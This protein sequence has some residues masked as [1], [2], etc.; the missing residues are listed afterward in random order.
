M[1]RGVCIAVAVLALT[2][3]PAFAQSTG[4]IVGTVTDAVTSAP[5]ASG[6]SSDLLVTLLHSS[7]QV[8]GNQATNALG[9]Y[10]F[11]GLTPG[12]YFVKVTTATTG[13]IP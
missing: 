11:T 8:F 7:G 3:T 6:G 10:A 2:S 13:Y 1:L 12:I 5:L 4:T 9:Q